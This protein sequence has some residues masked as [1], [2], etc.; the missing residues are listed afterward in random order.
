M[1]DV[2]EAKKLVG[3]DGIVIASIAGSS[4]EEWEDLF[5]LINRSKADMCELK[6]SCPYAAEM[7][8]KIRAGA[9][10]LAPMITEIAKKDLSIPFSVK[11]SVFN[12]D[13]VGIA[14]DVEKAGAD[15]ITFPART[16]GLM[17]DVETGKPMAWS[18]IGGYGGPYQIGHG[19]AWAARLI[20]AKISIPILATCGIWSWEDII[21]Y[22]MVGATAIE[23]ATAIAIRGYRIVNTW[24]REIESFMQRKGYDTLSE[25]RGISLEALLKPS[26]IQRALEDVHSKVDKKKCT[27]CGVCLRTCFYD[28]IRLERMGAIVDPE[29]CDG[30]G[31]CVEVCPYDAIRIV[32]TDF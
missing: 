2:N 3:D 19:L 14:K 32:R 16:S 6:V 25:I 8:I 31:M 22:I 7:E 30:C 23:S 11:L 12:N 21:S 1:N 28:A 20:R 26:E 10:E 9:V 29:K 15:A 13:P 18:A 24:L 17:I 4:V 5:N 27:M